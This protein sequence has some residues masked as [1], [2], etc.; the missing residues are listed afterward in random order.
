MKNDLDLG[1]FA[2]V[3]HRI[4]T[5]SATPIKQAARRTP[6]GFQDEE[7]NHLKLLLEAGVIRPSS[8]EWASPVVLVRKKDGGVRWCVDYR[9]LNEVTVGV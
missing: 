7:E 8:S 9:R 5:G 3:K 4:E 6:L 1:E 2:G